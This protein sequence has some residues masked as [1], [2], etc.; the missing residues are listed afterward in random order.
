MATDVSKATIMVL[1]ILT[2]V[3]SVISTLIIL[4]RA[5]Q[6]Q[7]SKSVSVPEQRNTGVVKLNIVRND[8]PKPD[9]QSGKVSIEIAK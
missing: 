3:I 6:L 1:L 7:A 2:I 8:P 4:D 9:Y 5:E